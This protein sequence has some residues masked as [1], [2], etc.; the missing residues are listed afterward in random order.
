[1]EDEA[2]KIKI[3]KDDFSDVLYIWTIILFVSFQNI[4]EEHINSNE[5]KDYYVAMCLNII[6]A[7]T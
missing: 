4:N 7:V 2:Q 1:M 6:Y 3:K 5:Q